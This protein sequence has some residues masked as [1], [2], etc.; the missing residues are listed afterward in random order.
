M[1]ENFTSIP[2]CPETLHG[3]REGGRLLG[4]RKRK[5]AGMGGTKWEMDRVSMEESAFTEEKGKGEGRK[6]K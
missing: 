3:P 5:Q 1:Q 6:G 4:V 2:T